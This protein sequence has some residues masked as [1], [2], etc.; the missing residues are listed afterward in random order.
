MKKLDDKILPNVS[1]AIVTCN[2]AQN[3]KE[4]LSR[5]DKQD[6]PKEKIEILV[7]DGGSTDGTL[8]VARSFESKIVDGGFKANAEPRRG[9]SLFYATHGIVAYIDSDI[10]LPNSTWLRE[11]VIPFIEDKEIVAT[12]PLFYEYRKEDSL[13]NRYF[14]LIGNHDPVAYY[15]KKTDR[16]SWGQEKWNLL[17]KAEDKGSYFKV[18][19]NHRRLPPLGCNGFFVKKSAILESALSNPEDIKIFN[20]SDAAYLMVAKGYNTF[21]FVKNSVIHKTSRGFIFSWIKKRIYSTENLYFRKVSRK[22]RVYDPKSLWDNLNLLKFIIYTF[23]IIKPLYDSLR[24]FIRKQDLAWFMHPV[25]CLVMLYTYSFVAIKHLIKKYLLRIAEDVQMLDENFNV[26]ILSHF[27]VRTEATGPPV[28]LKDFLLPKV[29]SIVYIEHPF[30]YNAW[31]DE[32]TRSRITVFKHGKLVKQK[33]F[34]PWRGNNV[35]YYIK[36]VL[37]TQWWVLMNRRRFD[38]CIALDNLNTL[39]VLFWRKLG[40]IKKLVYYTIDYNPIRFTNRLLNGIYH[41]ID[42]I[43]CYDSDCIWVLADRMIEGRKRKG[44]SIKRCAPTV[45][46]PMGAHLSRIK[47]VPLEKVERYTLV[48]VGTLSQRQGVQLILRVLPNII[49]EVP[50]VKF[51]V[52]GKGDYEEQLKKM[53]K[54]LKIEQYVI[55]KGFL[56]DNNE[57]EQILSRSAIGMA[58]YVPDESN[59]V[60]YADP[61]K[62]KQYLGCGLPVIITRF[63]AIADEIEKNDAGIAIDYNENSLKRAITKLLK[64]DDSYANCRKKAIEFSKSFDTEHI[65]SNALNETLAT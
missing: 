11:M 23:T 59:Y 12:Q 25:M 47:K 3:L 54:Q 48:Y 7:V 28:D 20:H 22:Y 5:I 10:F 63:P 55:F 32:D 13:L 50:Q 33:D 65:L 57:V 60:Y 6:Y 1:I 4:C 19:F 42:K 61:G 38:L 14:S 18:K 16:F 51:I 41:K 27:F 21:G 36:D 9:V 45:I 34:L 52:I 35:L 26:L 64:D 2:C 8:E 15:L 30:P 46:V 56:K 49:K 43:C 29:K 53:V 44:I 24:G 40:L 17:G 31:Q 58:C 37:L 62:P 39:S